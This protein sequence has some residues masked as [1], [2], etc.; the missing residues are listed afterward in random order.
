MTHLHRTVIHFEVR[1]DFL[2]RKFQG[3]N[4]SWKG[5]RKDRHL[6]GKLCIDQGPWASQDLTHSPQS[7][8]VKKCLFWSKIH[9]S[10]KMLSFSMDECPPENHVRGGKMRW[11]DS[12]F[13][14][15]VFMIL[16]FF[17]SHYFCLFSNSLWKQKVFNFSANMCLQNP[18]LLTVYLWIHQND[19][20]SYLGSTVMVLF[21]S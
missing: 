20:F 3:L 10:G 11:L 18:K 12:S 7:D 17:L 4:R 21:A 6:A 16:S 1:R 2:S 15:L 14:T 5:E 19:Y 8:T 9:N 13:S